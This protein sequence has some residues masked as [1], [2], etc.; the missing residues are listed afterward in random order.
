MASLW[1]SS[2]FEITAVLNN[3]VVPGLTETAAYPKIMEKNRR[4]GNIF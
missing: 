4:M 1:G 2:T 3:R